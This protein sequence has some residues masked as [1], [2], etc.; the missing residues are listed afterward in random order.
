MLMTVKL[1]LVFDAKLVRHHGIKTVA[2]YKS[3]TRDVPELSFADAPVVFETTTD[4]IRHDDRMSAE[5]PL[6]L[7]RGGNGFALRQYEGRLFRRLKEAP[8][9][10][11]DG[12]DAEPYPDLSNPSPI[13]KP[14]RLHYEHRHFA[15]AR[16]L[17]Y[18]TWPPFKGHDDQRNSTSFEAVEPL[19]RELDEESFLTCSRMQDRRLDGII[20]INGQFWLETSTPCI[21]VS[22][23]NAYT[24]ANPGS[25]WIKT[26]FLPEW[27]DRRIT[28]RY[29]PLDEF[30]GARAYAE[31]LQAMFGARSG[32]IT[33]YR[34]STETGSSPATEFDAHD[35]FRQRHLVSL[36]LNY[37]VCLNVMKLPNHER[38]D[39]PV[40]VAFDE[41]LRDNC[42]TGERADM[43][44]VADRL[45]TEVDRIGRLTSGQMLTNIQGESANQAFFDYARRQLDDDVIN[46]IPT[47]TPK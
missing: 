28:T 5:F 29:F 17:N 30:D 33:D 18:K 19:V 35:E 36:A 25:I 42:V 1:P 11:E 7:P 41:A 20:A 15:L 21:M 22:L 46:I 2:I 23:T 14:I 12:M 34:S 8:H 43:D 27:H 40:A 39:H 24:F 32:N 47:R 4:G 13:G 37:G 9:T 38:S 31:D 3:F 16:G 26:A 45:V 6:I 10:G 44:S